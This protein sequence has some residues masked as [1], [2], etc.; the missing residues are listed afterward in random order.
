MSRALYALVLCS[1]ALLISAAKVSDYARSLT[2]QALVDYVNSHQSLWKA[3]LNPNAKNA[4][5]GYIKN[6]KRLL[7]PKKLAESHDLDV[8]IPAQFDARKKWPKCKSISHIRDQSSCGSCWAFAATEVM[9]DRVCI[10]SQGKIQVSLS[11]VDVTSC[12]AGM[13]G[14]HG[15]D[16]GRAFEYWH[17]EGVVTGSDNPE[18]EGC[19]PYP[20]KP[21][22]HH[23]NKTT[24]PQCQKGYYDTPDCKQKC[25]KSYT[26]RSYKKDKFY[27]QEPYDIDGGAEAIQKEILEHGPVS[28]AFEVY[29]DF[30][31]YSGKDIYEHHGGELLGGHAVRVIGWGKEKGTPYW[32]VA[33]SWNTDWGNE[34]YFLIKRGVDECEIESMEVS[35]ALADLKRSPK[36]A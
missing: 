35:A 5:L 20:F 14:C 25:Q 34:G 9:S 36:S 15:G 6:T 17:E 21:C 13:G 16:P 30:L 8:K 33:N 23:T 4:T 7:K 11:A 31:H 3:E 28:V 24:Y 29:E 19:L 22:E 32:L 1:F 12:T 26:K 10:A 27:G 18:H 2:G